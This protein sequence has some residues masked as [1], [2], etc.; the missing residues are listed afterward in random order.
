M[1]VEKGAPPAAGETAFRGWSDVMALEYIAHRRTPYPIAQFE[2]FADPF[3]VAQAWIIE[4]H[5]DN[6]RFPC[7]IEIRMPSALLESPLSSDP[8]T[9]PFQNSV[10]LE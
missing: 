1:T 5:L 6:Q 3:L 10:G 7:G 8:F 2:N 4:C 9:R